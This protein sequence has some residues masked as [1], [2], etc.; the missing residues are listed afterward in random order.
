MGDNPH[1]SYED[2]SGLTGRKSGCKVVRWDNY[3]MAGYFLRPEWFHTNIFMTQ[4]EYELDRDMTLD[5]LIPRKENAL[6]MES[7]IQQFIGDHYQFLDGFKD[8]DYKLHWIVNLDLDV[9]YTK[10]SHVQLFSDD[11]I[12]RIA[13]LL[14][15][16]LKRIAV[17][18]IAISPECL[19]GKHLKDKWKNGF[20]ILRIMSEKLECLKDLVNAAEE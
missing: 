7:M 18:T 15:T 19:G 17:L 2:Y 4:Q 20:R 13:E 1:M 16:Y 9:F 11:Y 5:G 12:R 10:Y 6:Y 14:Q 3:I 8:N